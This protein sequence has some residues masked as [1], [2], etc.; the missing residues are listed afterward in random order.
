MKL[1]STLFNKSS[2]KKKENIYLKIKKTWTFY[3]KKSSMI[4][5][6]FADTVVMSKKNIYSLETWSI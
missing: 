2:E 5:L 6:R 1:I 3:M 4:F